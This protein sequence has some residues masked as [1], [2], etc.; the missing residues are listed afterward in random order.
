MPSIPRMS[1]PLLTG[2]AAAAPLR[3]LLV[4]DDDGDALIVEDLLEETAAPVVVQHVRTMAEAIEVAGAHDCALLDLQLPDATG[5]DGLRR[6]RGAADAL[7][8]LVLTGLADEQRGIEALAAGAQD[9]LVKGRVDGG[10]LARSIRYAVERRRAQHAQRQ[11]T[12]ARVTASENARLER[13]LLPTPLV[14][15]H[16]LQVCSHY[17]AGRRR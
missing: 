9:Y 2:E 4:E 6:L 16:R 12:L 10:L 1:G 5:I 17:R 3:V 11:L 14:T 15:D 13:G 7:A 8:I